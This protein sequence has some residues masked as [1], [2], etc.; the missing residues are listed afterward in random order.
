MSVPSPVAALARVMLALMFVMAGASKFANLEGTA[1]YIA[2]GGLPMPA[3]L[4][5]LTAAL[6]LLGGL[7]LALGFQARFAA[8]A[9][10]VFTVVAS[11]LFHKFW[12]VPAEQVMVQQLMF[13]KNIAVA[14]GLLFVF[15]LG[16]GPASL[17]NRRIAA[18]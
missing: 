4:A 15:S 8:L 6:E 5:V 17:D 10:A 2:S 18:A 12:A 14:G 16:A 7:A 3:V 13:M 1:G 11:L 9:L